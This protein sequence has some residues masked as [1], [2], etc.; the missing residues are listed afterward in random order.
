MDNAVQQKW[1]TVKDAAK[2]LG[3]TPNALYKMVH[4]ERVPHHRVPGT[5]SI[6]FLA[7]ELDEWMKGDGQTAS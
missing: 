3:L 6:R 2:Y 5:L 1:L 7:D 4:I